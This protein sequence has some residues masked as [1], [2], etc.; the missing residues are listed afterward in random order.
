[1]SDPENQLSTEIYTCVSELCWVDAEV[2][3]DVC[4]VVH[5]SHFESRCK[6]AGESSAVVDDVLAAAT[7]ATTHVT[8]IVK[9]PQFTVVDID[10]TVKRH[11]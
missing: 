10:A 1:V 3:C 7:D 11:R 2:T 6:F 8:Q 5:F 9:P 4:S